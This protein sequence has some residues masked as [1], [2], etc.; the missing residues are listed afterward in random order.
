MSVRFPQ[1]RID[2]RRDGV[3]TSADQLPPHL[4]RLHRKAQAHRR[5]ARDPAP[6]DENGKAWAGLVNAAEKVARRVRPQRRSDDDYP[7]I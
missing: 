2:G 1:G 6:V 3:Y 7:A 4:R 5:E